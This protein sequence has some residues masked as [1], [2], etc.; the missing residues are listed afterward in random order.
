MVRALSTNPIPAIVAILA[1][2]A[3]ISTTIRAK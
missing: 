3:S 2:K 1:E